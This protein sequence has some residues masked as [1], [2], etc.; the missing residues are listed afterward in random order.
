MPKEQPKFPT[1]AVDLPS[2]GLLYPKGHALS[3]GSI[4]IKYMTAREEDIL[5]SQNL[6]KKGV[7][8]DQLLKS[9]II[10]KVSLDEL[11]IGDKNAIMLAARILGY[12]KTYATDTTCT[13]CGAVEKE[14]EYDLTL[15][16]H[17]PIDENQF[18]GEN[19]FEFK[20]PN[21]G[22]V[23]EYKFMTHKDEQDAAIE[24][25][26]MKKAMGGRTQEVTTRLRKQIVS[27]DGN[28]DKEFINNFINNEFFAMDSRAYRE[29]YSESQP[30][31]DFSTVFS[32]PSCGENSDVD[33]P[34]SVNFFWPSR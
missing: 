24:V 20:L 26:R 9:L 12:G 10:S 2:K 3:E 17:K 30:D 25:D 11:L 28:E 34:I 33:L 18:K 5:T 16:E 31:I 27:V 8:I 32:C 6:I 15:F 22:R 19:K 14:C 21:S 7:V 29:H 13:H 4:E 1:E 23:I